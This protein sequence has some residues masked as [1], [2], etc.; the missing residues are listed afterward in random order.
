MQLMHVEWVKF[1]LAISIIF[2]ISVYSGLFLSNHLWI[3]DNWITFLNYEK[4][5]SVAI[6]WS[7]NENLIYI[8]HKFCLLYFLFQNLENV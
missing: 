2:T 7:I 3:Y 4:Y 6:N 5:Y 8:T 1:E